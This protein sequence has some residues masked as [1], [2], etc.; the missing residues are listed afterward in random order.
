MND[1]EQGTYWK[2]RAKVYELALDDIMAHSKF[3]A[4]Q[5]NTEIHSSYYVARS[6]LSKY[7][8]E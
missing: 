2:K 7:R 5:S 1:K 4:D 3:M 6:V 8:Q